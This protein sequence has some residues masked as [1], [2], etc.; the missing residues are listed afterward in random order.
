MQ[1]D[2]EESGMLKRKSGLPVP[3]AGRQSS[4]ETLPPIS[5]RSSGKRKETQ[6]KNASLRQLGAEETTV[7]RE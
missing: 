2:K 4:R 7:K 5:P 1:E 3:S 6:I